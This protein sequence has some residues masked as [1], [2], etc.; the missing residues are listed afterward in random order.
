M[1]KLSTE[2]IV[3]APADSVWEVVGR[4]FHR[5]GDWATAIRA[6]T[7]IPALAGPPT[8]MPAAA[9]PSNAPVDFAAPVAGRVC[10]VG[11]PLLPRVEERLIAYDEA[12]RTLTYEARG[13]PAFVT[14]ARNTWK[15]V[16]LDP[17]R[18]RVE[19]EA[20]FDTHGVLGRLGRWVILAQVGRTTRHLADDLRHYVQQG[21]PS[22][23]KERQLRRARGR[24]RVRHDAG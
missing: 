24:S 21:T 14:S 4:R 3:E 16:P 1:P 10:E 22:P 23:R 11:L 15:V 6:S 20:Q 8:T 9:Q 12:R 7:A 19:I 5:I 17:Q 2:L 13:M 18:T